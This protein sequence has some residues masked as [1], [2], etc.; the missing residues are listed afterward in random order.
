MKDIIKIEKLTKTYEDNIILNNI[1]LT[2]TE[3]EFVCLIGPSGE[4]KTT[5][6]NLIGGFIEKDSGNIKFQGKEIRK[7]TRDCIMVFQEFDQ[8]F[9]W[10]N[11]KENIGFPLKNSREKLSME[12]INNLSTK[13]IE[14]VKLK[15]FEN[16]YPHQLSG[17]MK[18]RVALARA[19]ATS[20]KVLL[21]DEPF[22]SLDAQTKSNLQ[23][24][25]FDI[26]EKT[27]TT[28]VFVTHDVKEALTLADRIILLKEG[29]I[30]EIIDN[31]N[32]DTSEQRVKEITRLL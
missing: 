23:N 24:I 8:L 12:E 14:M 19:L 17:G 32:R 27:K 9:S 1:D 31:M 16:H 28:I 6:L 25:L 18:Q 5:L 22:G 13:Y 20:P 15:G 10:K 26:W 30:K 21:M 2:I 3:G 29:A 11:L 4:G 7:P